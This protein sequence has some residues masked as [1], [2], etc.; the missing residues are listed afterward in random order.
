MLQ[1]YHLGCYFHYSQAVFRKIQN[2]GLI[3]ACMNIRPFQLLCR[4]IFSLGFLPIDHVITI[5]DISKQ[6]GLCRRLKT[7]FPKVDDLV[8]YVEK[9]WIQKTGVFMWNVFDRPQKFRKVNLHPKISKGE[10]P[11]PQ[12]KVAFAQCQNPAIVEQL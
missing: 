11:P 8:N 1:V 5:V 2:F 12:K 10:P 3:I 7:F 9:T 6:S 4:K